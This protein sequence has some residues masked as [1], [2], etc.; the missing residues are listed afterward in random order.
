MSHFN[1][2]LEIG[3]NELKGDIDV[4]LTWYNGQR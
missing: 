1:R 3:V 4:E 2:Q